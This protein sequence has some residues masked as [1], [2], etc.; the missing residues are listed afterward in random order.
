MDIPLGYWNAL[1]KQTIL[2]SSLLSGFSIA[3]IASILAS[4]KEGKMTNALVK[5]ATVTASSFLVTV[6][7]MVQIS[8]MT[9]PGYPFG[10]EGL[11]HSSCYWN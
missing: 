9:T 3:F 8:M 1:A 2:I 7:A 11:V 10:Y 6:F 4:E 5:V